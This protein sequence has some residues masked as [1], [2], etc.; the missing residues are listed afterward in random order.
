[1]R[2]PWGLYD[3]GPARAISYYES[4]L[5]KARRQG[6]VMLIC[7]AEGNLFYA[8][9]YAGERDRVR[10]VID[11]FIDDSDAGGGLVISGSLNAVAAIL[12][13]SGEASTAVPP[14]VRALPIALSEGTTGHLLDG[15]LV[16]AALAVK[17]LR[18]EEAERLLAAVSQHAE[19]LGYSSFTL[20]HDCRQAAEQA[21]RDS[22][23]SVEEA[24]MRHQPVTLDELV[25]LALNAL[26]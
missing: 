1:M 22:G 15:A 3:D 10:G 14:L 16:A 7:A 5:P 4:I 23:R 25:A 18:L 26:A 8:L 11:Q 13:L 20:Y 6:D 24:Q 21:I 2:Y 12:A 19:P 17:Q 9:H